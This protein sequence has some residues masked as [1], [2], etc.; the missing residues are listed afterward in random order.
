M[1]VPLAPRYSW[2]VVVIICYDRNKIITHKNFLGM[3]TFVPE[4]D[5]IIA[6]IKDVIKTRSISFFQYYIDREVQFD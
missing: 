4:K 5:I 3:D 2:D 1:R 6:Q